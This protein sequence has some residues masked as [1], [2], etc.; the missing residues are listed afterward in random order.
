M[1]RVLK[2]LMIARMRRFVARDYAWQ[3]VAVFYVT[4]LSAVV[5]R[6]GVSGPDIGRQRPRP[7]RPPATMRRTLPA[8]HRVAIGV[9]RMGAPRL[10][11]SSACVGPR[12]R[13]QRTCDRR[14]RAQRRREPTIAS[15]QPKCEPT[16]RSEVRADSAQR[17]ASR[18]RAAK[19]R[20]ESAQRRCDRRSRAR[21]DRG[22]CDGHRAADVAMR[23]PRRSFPVATRCLWRETVTTRIYRRC[24]AK[25]TPA[26]RTRPSL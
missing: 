18:Q 2:L 19:V 4:F 26:V 20:V 7:R 22:I 5:Y 10:F 8:R 21:S 12:E 16:A 25:L 9:A 24:A 23:S 15:A 14:S 3:R 6:T 17:S 13:A 11:A 1:C